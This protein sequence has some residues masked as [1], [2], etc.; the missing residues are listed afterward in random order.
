MEVEA[1]AVDGRLKEAEAKE[2]LTA[3]ASLGWIV[4]LSSK[5]KPQ[6][7]NLCQTKNINRQAPFSAL[8]FCLNFC[9]WSNSIFLYYPLKHRIFI[10]VSQS[11]KVKLYSVH[12]TFWALLFTSFMFLCLWKKLW[13]HVAKC[14]MSLLHD[15]YK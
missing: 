4:H 10:L 15:L 8:V 5:W 11:V 7:S 6:P 2:N 9:T 1:E 12:E 13:S 14:I 3:V